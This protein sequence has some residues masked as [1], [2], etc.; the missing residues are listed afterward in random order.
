M[1]CDTKQV[2]SLQHWFSRPVPENKNDSVHCVWLGQAGFL[3]K[4]R[5]LRV[6]IDPYLSD[7]LANKYRGKEFPH[8]RMMDIP[9]R[10]EELEDL[11]VVLCSH[12]HTDHMDKE[13]LLPLYRKGKGPLLIAPRSELP[14]LLEMGL[15][16]QRLIGLS[17]Y[18]T[19]TLNNELSIEAL[20][21]AHETRMYDQWGN[22]KALGY[23]LEFGP[24]SF[25][26]SGD[27]LPID[28]LRNHLSAKNIDVCLLPVNGRK[29]SLSEKGILGNFSIGEAGTFAHAINASFL[30][31]HH[32]GMF[33]FNTVQPEEIERE[34]EALD[35]R[36]G[37][38]YAIPQINTIYTFTKEKR[39]L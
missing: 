12:G 24:L 29:P 17:E 34:L 30:I 1:K 7:S 4:T 35:W 37:T 31:P 33:D 32:F 3:F 21:A 5:T 11:D 14:R 36:V 18:E 8:L 9:I 22:S 2:T 10:S 23:L 16:P 38:T 13:T 28:E 19:F 25:F 27:S 6:A 20:P 15:P 39:S 26:H